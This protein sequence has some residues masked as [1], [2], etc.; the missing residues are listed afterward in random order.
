MN[1]LCVDIGYKSI[2]HFGEQLCGDHVDVVEQ[3]EKF[4][5]YRACRRF[6]QRRKGK[7]FV[8]AHV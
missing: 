6:G 4:D 2:N 3:D 7:Y 8:D 1:D 5:G